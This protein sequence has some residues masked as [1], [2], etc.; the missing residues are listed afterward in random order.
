MRGRDYINPA[1]PDELILEIF[2]RLDSKTRRDACSLVCKRWLDLERLSRDTIR[3][4]ASSHPDLQIK[5]LARHFVN[6]RNVYV[7][8]RLSISLP[9]QF[10]SFSGLVDS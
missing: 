2:R 7:D 10:V 5:L 9:V 6:I 8:E 4:G 3:V 1:L